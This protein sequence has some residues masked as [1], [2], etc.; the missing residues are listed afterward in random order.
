MAVLPTF[1]I[2]PVPFAL[3]TN[4]MFDTVL[5]IV[6]CSDIRL[7]PVPFLNNNLGG[8][9]GLGHKYVVS[10]VQDSLSVHNCSGAGLIVPVQRF[11]YVLYS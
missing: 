10:C 3:N 4:I 1:I 5:Q 11:V 8:L 9:E 7:I 2:T 6:S